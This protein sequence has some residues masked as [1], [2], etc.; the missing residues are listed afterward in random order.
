MIALILAQAENGVI[1]RDGGLP[2]HLPADLR[3]FKAL[4]TG[5][6]LVMGRKTYE[7]I[8]R[9]LPDRQSIVITRNRDL[10]L[11]G[12]EV[13]HSLE[14]ALDRATGEVFVIGGAGI[15]RMAM[16]LAHRIYRTVVHADV[17]GDVRLDWDPKGWQLVAEDHLEADAH[18]AHPLTFEVWDRVR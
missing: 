1:G 11:D 2:W 16:P 18:H 14:E 3:R 5:H 15:Y 12:V 17:E 6:C 8:G 10:H 9:P 13:V 4:T 7:S